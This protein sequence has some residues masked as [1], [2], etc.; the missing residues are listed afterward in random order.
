MEKVH[1]VTLK[2]SVMKKDENL[3]YKKKKKA[4]PNQPNFACKFTPNLLNVDIIKLFSSGPL[5]FLEK[6]WLS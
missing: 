6:K 4:H 3:F 5:A 2:A 1:R